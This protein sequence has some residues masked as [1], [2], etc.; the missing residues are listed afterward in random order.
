M[1]QYETM[2]LLDAAFAADFEQAK[3]EVER[4]LKRAKAKVVF[5]EKWDERR[6]AYEIKGCKR[7]C[8]V[9]AYYRCDPNMIAQIERDCALSEPILRVL[10]KQ[11]EGVTKDQMEGYLPSRRD[12]DAPYRSE[13]GSSRRDSADRASGGRDSDARASGD[14][15][16]EKPRSRRPE[17]ETKDADGSAKPDS[18]E[19][20]STVA[21]QTKESDE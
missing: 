9:L 20:D 16:A 6:L 12:E 15:S 8:Y 1:N 4:I 19:S 21:V 10:V 17:A 2:F 18:V 13:G 14:R 11:A 5:L 7:G 3:G